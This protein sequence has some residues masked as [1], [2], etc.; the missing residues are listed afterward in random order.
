MSTFR[1]LAAA[2]IVLFIAVIAGLIIRA[3]KQIDTEYAL[4]KTV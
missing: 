3:N 2:V 4:E 1:K